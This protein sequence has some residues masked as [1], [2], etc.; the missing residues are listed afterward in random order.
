MMESLDGHSAKIETRFC[1]TCREPFL[2]DLDKEKWNTQIGY[3][4]QRECYD[5]MQAGNQR[6]QS[7]PQNPGVTIVKKAFKYEFGI[8]AAGAILMG[9][10]FIFMGA[11]VF[12]FIPFVFSLFCFIIF[13]VFN[14][15]D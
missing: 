10:F 5:C 2:V 13:L 8:A 7:A 15:D 14:S 4:P 6:I 11:G 12:S 9:F 3:E 1:K